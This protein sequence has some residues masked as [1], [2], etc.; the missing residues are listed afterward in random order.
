MA[1]TISTNGRKKLKTLQD[2]FNDKF[3]HLKIEF[4]SKP[5]EYDQNGGFSKKFKLNNNKSL[6]EVRKL[7]GKG[8][9]S[10]N[11]RKKIINIEKEFKNIFGLYV[12]IYGWSINWGK[13]LTDEEWVPTTVIN[14]SLT[15]ANDFNKKS[16]TLPKKDW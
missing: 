10:L 12:V 11:G 9:I 6:S 13:S 2:E 8:E 15:K 3:S 14:Y 16:K 4:F 1:T 7:K 5:I